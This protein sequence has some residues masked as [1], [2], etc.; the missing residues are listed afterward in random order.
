VV[1]MIT[2]IEIHERGHVTIAHLQGI[3]TETVYFDGGAT[4][5]YIDIPEHLLA[6]TEATLIRTT[7]GIA[8][9]MEFTGVAFE[10]TGFAT[11]LPK[12]KTFLR[13]LGKDETE[14][15]HYI[16]MVREML[17]THKL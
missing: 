3:T 5:D 12:M 4:T 2:Q 8:A 7:A 6:D 16:A 11:D 10:E 17:R 15:P 14:I 9:E 13:W 1:S